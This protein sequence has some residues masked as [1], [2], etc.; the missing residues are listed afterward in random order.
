[1]TCYEL[2]NHTRRVWPGILREHD[3]L[4]TAKSGGKIWLDR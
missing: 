2:V 1:M 3:R 4:H